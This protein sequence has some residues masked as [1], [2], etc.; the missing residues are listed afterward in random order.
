MSGIYTNYGS[1]GSINLTGQTATIG[2]IALLTAPAAG[3]YKVDIYMAKTT[4]GTSG[5]VTCTIGYTDPSSA[6]TQ[7]TSAITFG[8]TG[9]I[10]SIFLCEVAS[11]NLTY[12]TTVTANVGGQYSLRISVSRTV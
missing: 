4:A 9:F 7:V 1:L 8:S 12:A 6:A 3:L 11:G 5:T 2:S 10:S